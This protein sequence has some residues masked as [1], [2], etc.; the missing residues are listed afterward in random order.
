MCDHLAE[1]CAREFEAKVDRLAAAYKCG[2]VLV[3]SPFFSERAVPVDDIPKLK[4]LV[5]NA[6]RARAWHGRHAPAWAQPLPLSEI[7]HEKIMCSGYFHRHLLSFYSYS[8]QGRDFNFLEHPLF[9]DY[10]R[11]A[12]AAHLGEAG[13]QNDRKLLAEFPPKPLAGLDAQGHWRP[14]PNRASKLI[15]TLCNF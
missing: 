9:Y 8:L 10:C 5:R 4:L 1:Q 14:L 12:M 15:E 6:L 7:E 3:A 11:G 13:L 2:R